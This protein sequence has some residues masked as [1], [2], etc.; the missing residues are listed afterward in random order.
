MLAA[1]FWRQQFL[2]RTDIT[3]LNHGSFGAC[4]R[5]VFA[6]YQSWQRSIEDDPVDFF[7]RRWRPA[8]AEA[9][10]AL[11][12]F[13]SA[14]A[15][16]LVY[17][18]NTTYGL[19]ALLRSL[20]LRPGD[21][22]LTSDHE[23]D[24]IDRLWR[25]TCAQRGAQYRVQPITL[26]LTTAEAFVEDLWAGVTPRTRVIALSHITS[27][28][29]LIF[30]IA[31][32]CARARAAGI[33]TVIDGA[34]APGQIDL[35]LPALG[36]DF[37]VG[38]CHKWLCAPKGSGFLY[39]RREHQAALDPF[40]IGWGWQADDP[41][42]SQFIDY[43]ERIG[44]NDP[45]AYLATPTAISFQADHKWPQL[46]LASHALLREA[47]QRIGAF[48]G[49]EALSPSSP[50]FFMQMRSIPLPSHIEVSL[51]QRLWQEYAIEVPIIAWRQRRFVRVSIQA[52]N[53][54]GDVDR[55]VEAL[56]RVLV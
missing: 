49:I 4:P 16:D 13:L 17:V 11:A 42:E 3:F 48:S 1:H 7:M 12:A 24:A 43:F 35:D 28:T 55:L 14:E 33:L 30:P 54:P 45:S 51:S 52:Y 8:L 39:V 29:A 47:E 9:R 38:N 56:T 18:E 53:T 34:H 10:A 6:A 15:D 50:E 41:G 21:E 40:I 19:N 26:P 22:V 44:T 2:L 5:P 25:Y 23:Y 46:R 36:A 32:I 20:D 27:A 31:A 37:Y